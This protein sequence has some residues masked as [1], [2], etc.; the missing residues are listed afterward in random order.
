MEGK[1]LITDKRVSEIGT[2]LGSMISFNHTKDDIV[3][4]GVLHGAIP[5]M[6]DLMKGLKIPC[7]IDT[8][9]CKSY[10]G[11]FEKVALTFTKYPELNLDN[12][13][14]VIVEDIVDTGDTITAIK[15]Y[16]KQTYKN[17]KVVV[18]S[19]LVREGCPV[20]VEYPGHVVGKDVWVYGYGM[21]NDEF[22]RNISHVMCKI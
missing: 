4:L 20:E 2:F 18:C 9:R 7:K 15:A 21:D 14:I 22:D 16:L 11:E 17:V 5:F 19:L 8:I 3:L 1:I 12:H 13:T 6:G 10:V